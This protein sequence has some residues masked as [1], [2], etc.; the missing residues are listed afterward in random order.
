[1]KTTKKLLSAVLVLVM[2]LTTMPIAFAEGKTYE[3][4]DIIKFGSYPQSEVKDEA[5]IAELNSL[6][7]EWDDWTSYESRGKC[8]NI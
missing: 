7:P 2:L 5:L 8:V 3:V 4:G 6:A 1:M